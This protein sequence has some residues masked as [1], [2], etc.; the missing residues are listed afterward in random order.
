MEMLR[1]IGEVVTIPIVASGGAGKMEDFLEL[2][3]YDRIDAG[4][5]AGIFHTKQVN[6]RELKEYLAVNGVNVRL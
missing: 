2:F 4:L 6:I 3:K 1:A 5:A